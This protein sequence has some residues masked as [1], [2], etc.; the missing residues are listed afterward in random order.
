M[1]LY[2]E[3][4]SNPTLVCFATFASWAVVKYEWR[5]TFVRYEW[6]DAFGNAVGTEP[7]RV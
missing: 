6:M 1:S 2:T 3:M 4:C 5:H 7:A